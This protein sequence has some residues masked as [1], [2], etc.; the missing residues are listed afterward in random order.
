MDLN[1]KDLTMLLRVIDKKLSDAEDPEF[2]KSM[3]SVANFATKLI[4]LIVVGVADDRNEALDGVRNA[5]ADCETMV[6]MTY[7]VFETTGVMKHFN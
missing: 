3:C 2:G 1:D 7:D 5:L 4:A 6:N